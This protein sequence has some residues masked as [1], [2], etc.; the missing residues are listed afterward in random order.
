MSCI[1]KLGESYNLRSYLFI[2]INDN[3][4]VYSR[5]TQIQTL[6]S[7][8]RLLLPTSKWHIICFKPSEGAE[9]I[10]QGTEESF[11]IPIQELVQKSAE[12]LLG[13]GGQSSNH[14]TGRQLRESGDSELLQAGL[15]G[16]L[17]WRGPS[18]EQKITWSVWP[19]RDQTSCNEH[20]KGPDCGC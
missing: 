13:Q 8:L 9:E 3:A 16:C 17:T 10:L 2:P 18:Q 6:N 20:P 5:I 14:S 11:L 7:F 1:A 15:R 19:E 12:H 4:V